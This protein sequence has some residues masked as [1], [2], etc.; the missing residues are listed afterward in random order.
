V[1]EYDV[2]NTQRSRRRC[3][4][5]WL[6]LAGVLLLRRGV[7]CKTALVVTTGFVVPQANTEK[8]VLI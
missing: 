1:N 8:E 6:N 7:W 2:H 3:R 5:D 4:Q